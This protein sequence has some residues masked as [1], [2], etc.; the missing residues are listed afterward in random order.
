MQEWLD[1]AFLVTDMHVKLQFYE[2]DPWL[3]TSLFLW[4]FN[5]LQSS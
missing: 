5:M 2:R 1:F 3:N 4:R